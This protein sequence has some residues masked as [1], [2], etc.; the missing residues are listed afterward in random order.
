MIDY[1]DAIL[2]DIGEALPKPTTLLEALEFL[3]NGLNNKYG[4]SKNN[5]TLSSRWQLQWKSKS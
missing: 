2:L 1:C 4:L 3:T 5:T